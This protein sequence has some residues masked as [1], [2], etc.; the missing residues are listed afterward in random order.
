MKHLLMAASVALVLACSGCS[1]SSAP[2]TSNPG[3]V[4]NS[5]NTIAVPSSSPRGNLGAVSNSTTL[6]QKGV[7]GSNTNAGSLRESE[8][9]RPMTVGM[10]SSADRSGLNSNKRGGPRRN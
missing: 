2:Q 10:N 6:S 1:K 8:N 9:S 4:S 7:S 5:A 3:T